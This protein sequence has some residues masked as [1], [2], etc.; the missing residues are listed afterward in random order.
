MRSSAVARAS[1]VTIAGGWSTSAMGGTSTGKGHVAR[2]RVA[3]ASGSG[4]D[5]AGERLKQGQRQEV[6]RQESV[7]SPRA[8]AYSTG[9][10]SNVGECTRMSH[11]HWTAS[12]GLNARTISLLFLEIQYWHM[13]I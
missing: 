8:E 6:A 12:H 2:A 11:E 13:M 3:P 7:L 10:M 9:D 1:A 5:G 4:G